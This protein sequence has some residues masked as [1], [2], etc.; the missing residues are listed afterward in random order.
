M[1]NSGVGVATIDFGGFPGSNTAQVTVSGVTDITTGAHID[2]FWQAS[3]STTDH[4]TTDHMY[5]PLLA[6]LVCGSASAGSG[7]TIYAITE[8]EIMG[9]F[10]VKYVWLNNV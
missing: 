7:F 8:H 9:T 6:K 10:K 3:E 4:T 5:M 1:A 2:A